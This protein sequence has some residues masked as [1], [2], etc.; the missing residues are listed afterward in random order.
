MKLIECMYDIS[1]T[2][3]KA[4]KFADVTVVKEF[5]SYNTRWVGTHKNVHFWV[6]LEN[7]YAVGWNE[8]PS[9]GWSFPIVKLKP[10]I[11]ELLKK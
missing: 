1:C 3:D 11:F 8:S 2:E 10:E 7:G 6:V 4:Y 5:Y 9:R